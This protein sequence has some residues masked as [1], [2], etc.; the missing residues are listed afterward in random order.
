[1]AGQKVV[2]TTG[3]IGDWHTPVRVDDK[4]SKA[5]YEANLATR[6]VFEN[7]PT[8]HLKMRFVGIDD[9]LEDGAVPVGFGLLE[10]QD[11]DGDWL[12]GRIDWF[13]E[14]GIDRGR[15]TFS[16]GTGKWEGVEGTV[17]VTLFALPEDLEVEMPPRGPIRFYGFFEGEGELTVP[18]LTSAQGA[19]VSKTSWWTRSARGAS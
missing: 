6:V 11:A 5:A 17:D 1:M 13:T 3:G 15:Y 9:V 18:N 7:G 16:S 8:V 19:A 2:I 14:D 10:A 4:L 12:R